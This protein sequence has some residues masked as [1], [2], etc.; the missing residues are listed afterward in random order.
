MGLQFQPYRPL[1]LGSRF[2]L[3][4]LPSPRNQ[5]N[6]GATRSAQWQIAA[7]VLSLPPHSRSTTRTINTFLC[8]SIP[9]IFIASFWPGSESTNAK[10]VTR[11]SRATPVLLRGEARHRLVQNTCPG[12]NSKRPPFIQS[13]NRPSPST[14][15]E[16]TRIDST[17]FSC[18]WGG[19]PAPCVI[20]NPTVN[21]SM[22]VMGIFANTRLSVS[23]SGLS[24]QSSGSASGLPP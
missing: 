7:A 3:P 8:T 22:S 6:S 16:R 2:H 1:V 13:V 14:L 11:P 9:A 5:I 18:Q 21:G 12:S 17:R 19:P 10:K 15:H 23:Q 4:L 24:H 20:Q